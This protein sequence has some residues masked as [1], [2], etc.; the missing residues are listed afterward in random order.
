[1]HETTERRE[2]ALEP[3]HPYRLE[4]KRRLAL[5]Y[6]KVNDKPRMESL[7]WDVL[8]G[9]VKMLGRTHPYSVGAKVDLVQLLQEVGKWDEYGEAKRAID[10]LFEQQDDFKTWHEAF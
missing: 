5:M 7:Y 3:S 8:R 2:N 6:E 1:M 4:S 10:A 9:R